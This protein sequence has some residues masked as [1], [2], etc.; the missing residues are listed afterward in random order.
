MYA[1][2]HWCKTSLLS[3]AVLKHVHGVQGFHSQEFCACMGQFCI[4][5]RT[6]KTSRKSMVL[7]H[8]WFLDVI[9]HY[10]IKTSACGSP[11]G[12]ICVISVLLCRSADM[13]SR[14]TLCNPLSTLVLGIT[15]MK[16]HG[17][18]LRSWIKNNMWYF[19]WQ[20]IIPKLYI[21]VYMHVII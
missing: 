14:S 2:N 8:I 16:L 17:F 4:L 18:S 7:F 11:V 9:L 21:E 12:H 3:Q 13:S 20:L 1:L 19:I 5:P 10:F 15:K 6:K